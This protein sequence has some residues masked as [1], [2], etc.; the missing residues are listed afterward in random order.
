M[1]ILFASDIHLDEH[2]DFSYIEPDGEHSR[3]TD[4]LKLVERIPSLVEKYGCDLVI[5]AGDLF[6][7]PR[8]IDTRVYQRSFAV[9]EQVAESV[10]QM[11]LLTGNHDL[12]LFQQHSATSLY[13]LRRLPNTQVILEPTTLHGLHLMPYLHDR[14][15]VRM[16]LRNAPKGSVIVSHCGLTEAVVG[17]NEVQIDAPMSLSDVESV[18]PQAAFFGHY[19]TPQFFEDQNCFVIGALAQHNML[20]RGQ[21]RGILVYD[22][23]SDETTRVWLNGP[24]FFLYELDTIDQL[25]K[26]K[27]V[28]MRGG[29]VRILLRSKAIEREDVIKLLESM[30]VRRHQVRYAVKTEASQRSA[31]LTQRLLGTGIKDSLPDYVKHLRP[32][33]LDQEQLIKTGRQLLEAYD[34]TP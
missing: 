12:A 10:P 7:Q 19:H 34:A 26:L 2:S 6:H 27:T 9:L 3:L 31:K 5:L 24:K 30:E 11:I 23:D 32:P 33:D 1:K 20:D 28:D 4:L 29:Y 17:P 22:T 21:K 16:A 13:P 15:Q 14:S 8:T 25:Q 18:L